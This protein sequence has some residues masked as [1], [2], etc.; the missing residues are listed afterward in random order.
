MAKFRA[1]GLFLALQNDDEDEVVNLLNA[2]TDTKLKDSDGRTFLQ[3]AVEM[4]CKIGIIKELMKRSDIAERDEEGDTVLDKIL[5]KDDKQLDDVFIEFIDSVMYE[6][7]TDKLEEIVLA[8]WEVPRPSSSKRKQIKQNSEAIDVLLDNIKSFEDRVKDIHRAIFDGNVRLLKQLADKKNVG[9]ARDETGLFPL[10]KAIVYDQMDTLNYL[11]ENFPE[12]INKKDS[13]GRTPLHYAAVTTDSRDKYQ[14][15]VNAGAGEEIE[16]N[17]EHTPKYYLDHKDEI[18]L[19]A[20]RQKL[21]QILVK[22]RKHLKSRPSSKKSRPGSKTSE[23]AASRGSAAGSRVSSAG[24]GRQGESKKTSQSGSVSIPSQ[25]KADPYLVRDI[26]PPKTEDGLYCASVLGEALTLAL[27]EIVDK[28]PWDPIEFLGHWLQKY[29]A[30]QERLRK[31]RVQEEDMRRQ[32]IQEEQERLMKQKCEEERLKLQEEQ[33]Q[34]KLQAEEERRQQEEEEKRQREKSLLAGPPM[35]TLK[36][37]EQEDAFMKVDTI[38]VRDENGQTELHRAVIQEVFDLDSFMV[39][40]FNLGLRDANGKTPR[41]LAEEAERTE[42]VE[43]IDKYVCS[44]FETGKTD[45]I[46]VLVL[47]GYNKIPDLTERY[48]EDGAGLDEDAF[49]IWK[50]MSKAQ[51]ALLS[52]RKAVLKGSIRELRQSLWRKELSCGRDDAGRSFLHQAVLYNRQEIV[53]YLLENY[54]YLI[55]FKDNHDR[56][57]LHYALAVDDKLKETLL[58]AGADMGALDMRQNPPSYY[59]ENKHEILSQRLAAPEDLLVA[60]EEGDGLGI[61]GQALVV[62][63]EGLALEGDGLGVE[64]QGLAVEGEGLAVEGEGQAAEGETAEEQAAEGQVEEG[65]ATEGQAEEGQATEGQVE[66]G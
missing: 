44:L 54:P 23:K 48:G 41:E 17:K 47:T 7:D 30:N 15:L 10:H 26:P 43:A 9:K 37:E 66:E 6:G 3:H 5:E 19:V 4:K 46:K 28:R 40:G 58:N 55:H 57:P 22:P 20:F 25:V 33:R 45:A 60:E 35:P 18:D 39:R 62:E 56:T 8:G 13:Y 65:Q 36:E 64:G 59:E 21:S 38:N 24:S 50:N 34:Q 31:A 12:L 29:A 49:G 27:A 14:I 32:A 52:S 42:H 53:E 61:G 51:D 63:G 1:T 2:D 11:V 16:D